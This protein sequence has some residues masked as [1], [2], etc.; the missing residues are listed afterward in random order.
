[1]SETVGKP[2]ILGIETSCDETAAAVVAGGSQILSN[3]IASQVDL[4]ACFGGVVPEI[5]SR[6]HLEL[7]NG[8]IDKALY[9]TA[10]TLDDIDA[11]AVAYGPGLVGALLV[12]IAAAKALAFASDLPL[13]AVNHLEGHIYANF[14]TGREITFPLVCL[15]VSGGHTSLL[16][17]PEENK[18][19]LL[20]NTLDDAAGEAFDKIARAAGLGYP[21]GPV[22]DRLAVKGNPEAIAFPRA[23]MKGNGHRQF[24]FS[25]SG[26][27]S[28]VINYLR[29]Q[30]KQGNVVDKHDLAASFQAAVVEVLVKKTLEAA[31]LYRVK[32]V[33]LAGGVAANTCLRRSLAVQLEKENIKL[34][35]PPPE[36]CTDNAAMIA[37]AGYRHLLR[38]DFASLDLNAAPDLTL[39]FM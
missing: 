10:I 35:C 13:L 17:M 5:A 6:C 19:T 15:I 22:I 14:L 39:D 26:L 9:E 2:F 20:G 27:K 33:L 36:L 23:Y 12:G 11:V 29:C 38:S 34:L 21:G 25:F 31:R 30:H 28:S 7:I 16:H 1:M 32:Q 18:M 3:I 37:A 24:D 4:H 8:V